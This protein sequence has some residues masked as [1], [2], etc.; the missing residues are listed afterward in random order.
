MEVFLK[1]QDAFMWDIIQ[2]GDYNPTKVAEDGSTEKK[3]ITEMTPD[4]WHK[5]TLNSKAKLFL[6]CALGKT[7]FDKV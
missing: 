4:E 2:N 7:Q 6:I 3:P 1:S 5:Y